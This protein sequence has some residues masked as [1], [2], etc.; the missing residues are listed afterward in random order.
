MPWNLHEPDKIHKLFLVPLT[1]AV[2]V[3]GGARTPFCGDSTVRDSGKTKSSPML[4]CLNIPLS[5]NYTPGLSQASH[6]SAQATLTALLQGGPVPLQ[7]GLR[8]RGSESQEVAG[9]GQPLSVLFAL[10]LGVW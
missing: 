8:S 1:L 7:K 9:R 2:G 4:M 10:H 5:T 3:G 6:L